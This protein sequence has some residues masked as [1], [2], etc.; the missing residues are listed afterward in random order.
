MGDPKDSR[1]RLDA[2][3]RGPVP[4]RAERAADV[5]EVRR[6]LR[7]TR[8]EKQEPS[9]EAIQYRRDIP[10]VSAGAERRRVLGRHVVLA[11]AVQGEDIVVPGVGRAYGIVRCPA[12]RGEDWA[13]LCRSFCQ[14]LARAESGV[15]RR[16][17]ELCGSPDLSPSDLMFMDLEST[18][19]AGTPLFLIGTMSLEDGGLVIRQFFARDYS[20]ER[21]VISLFLD[22][23]SSR[24]LL[25]SFNG[26]TFDLPYVRVRAAANGM[27]F[28]VDLPHLDLLQECRR[29][30]RHALPDCKLQTLESYVCGRTR[31]GDIPGW[32]IPDAYHAF[33]RTGNAAEIVD[34]L[35]HNVRDLLT[36]AELLLRLPSGE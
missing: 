3:N 7:K 32:E 29:A 18:G 34:I 12:Q 30:W 6:K 10:R 13:A 2:L 20:E 27:P 9:A 31:H 4:R 26:K 17:V 19:L 1:K 36:L 24:R 21:A 16:L 23:V 25:V 5:E 33:V 35:E 15:R 8:R 22:A 11:E 28:S 14:S